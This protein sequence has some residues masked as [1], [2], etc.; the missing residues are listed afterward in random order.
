MKKYFI[1]CISICCL[2]VVSLL[3]GSWKLNGK[4]NK[5]HKAECTIDYSIKNY[6]NVAFEMEVN[7]DY[8][9]DPHSVAAN[10]TAGGSLSI[11]PSSGFCI[12][13]TVP[14]SGGS[15]TVSLRENLVVIAT[16]PYSS[17]AIYPY[18]WCS[19]QPLDCSATYDILIN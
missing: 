11:D 6:R 3:I 18:F 5:A 14:S 19:P 10:G 4:N 13:F 7:S 1:A 8:E 15:G 17:S 16:Y 2:L 12:I 9:G